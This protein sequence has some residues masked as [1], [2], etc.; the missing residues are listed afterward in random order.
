M[1][2]YISGLSLGPA[3]LDKQVS[4]LA[5][6]VVEESEIRALAGLSVRQSSRV[7]KHRLPNNLGSVKGAPFGSRGRGARLQQRL[8]RNQIQVSPAEFFFSQFG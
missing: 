1:R 8:A 3:N 4:L 2:V 6:N 7:L 5:R